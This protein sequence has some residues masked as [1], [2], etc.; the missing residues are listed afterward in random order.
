MNHFAL[1]AYLTSVATFLMGGFVFLRNRHSPTGKIFFA[2]SGTIALWAV[3]TATHS[4][5]PSETI[6]LFSAK[7]MHLFMLLIPVLFFHFT[8]VFLKLARNRKYLLG[9]ASAYG[10]ALA[11]G[12]LC[13]TGTLFVARVRPKL[14][15]VYFMEGGLLYP[16]VISFFVTSV[17]TGLFLL[18]KAIPQSVGEQRNQLLYLFWGSLMGYS[19]GSASFYPVYNITPFPYPYGSLGMTFCVWVMAC[20]VAKYR[21][22]EIEVLVKRTIVFTGLFAFV[23]GVFAFGLSV[24]QEILAAFLGF[25]WEVALAISIVLIVIG[26]DPMHAFLIEVTDKYLFQKKYDYRKFLKDASRGIAQIESLHHLLR[27]VTHSITLRMRLKN[28]AV[29]MRDLKSGQFRLGYLRGY[30]PGFNDGR[31]LSPHCALIRYLDREKEAVEIEQIREFVERDVKRRQRGETVFRYDFSEMKREMG[32]LQAACCIPS[33]LGKELRNILVLGGKKSGEFYTSEDLFVLSTLAQESATAIENARLY[34]EAVN[35][36]RDLQKINE[37][38]ETAQGRLAHALEETEKANKELRNTQAQLIHEQKMATLGRLAASVGHE[39]N[40]PLTILSMNVSRALL[41]YRKDPGL[42]VSEV[43]D[44]YQKMEQN[45]GRIKVVVNTLT[46]LLK[47][48]EKGKF[49]PLSLKLILEETLPLVQ[50]QT[51]LDNPTGTEVEFDVSSSLPLIRGDLER[52]Q[53]VF[54]NLFINA[55]HSMT[56]LRNRKIVVRARLSPGNP[57]M[58]EVDFTDNGS[59]MSGE[60]QKKIFTYGFTTK[61]QERG[62]GMGLYICKY[63]IEL[64]GGEMKVKSQVGAGTTFSLTLP[65]YE[66]TTSA[67][68]PGRVGYSAE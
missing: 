52:L 64:H 53:E 10:V 11:M 34:D 49:E 14:G 25:R 51:Y 58:V 43:L 30:P 54:L 29:L 61:G 4:V 67:G 5:A 20:A 8:L 66:E 26:Y 65:I 39:V 27:L 40:N 60:I 57:K 2:Y 59:G 44:L 13:L 33:F 68:M 28:A 22:L 3:L 55:Y 32:E 50:F 63:I 23:F 46:G 31:Q 18:L 48:S 36:S 9:L 15:Y 47:K 24:T 62:S 7:A 21:L 16:L 45:I 35:R 6:S 38:L 1:S 42:K 19:F 17:L 56:G 12:T 37:E 41:K